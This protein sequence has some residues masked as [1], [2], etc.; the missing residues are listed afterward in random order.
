MH[1]P[2]R[3]IRFVTDPIVDLA[4]YLI[5]RTVV[6]PLIRFCES[7][8][9][10]AFSVLTASL[11]ETTAV[12]VFDISV[13]MVSSMQCVLASSCLFSFFAVKPGSSSS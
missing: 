3:A 7:L 13:E 11:G 8:A 1:L 12:K 6:P 2:L 10:I 9:N 5:A 4:L